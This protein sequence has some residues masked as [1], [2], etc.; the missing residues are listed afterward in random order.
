MVILGLTISDTQVS[1]LWKLPIALQFLIPE[2]QQQVLFS[3]SEF[4]YKLS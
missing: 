3:F 2:A 4:M 1:G